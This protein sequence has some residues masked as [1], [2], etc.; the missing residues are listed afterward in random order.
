VVEAMAR[1]ARDRSCADIAVAV[2]G[3]AGPDGG[4]PQK[5]I[6][7]V[8]IGISDAAGTTS[9]CIRVPGDR[10]Y[11][12]RG[13]IQAAMQWLRWRVDGVDEALQWEQP[14]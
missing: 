2:S 5:P 14:S 8:W 13:T 10:S 12:R 6:G 4:S 11:V 7:T 9:R 1:G 3:V